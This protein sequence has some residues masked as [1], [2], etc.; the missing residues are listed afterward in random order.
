VFVLRDLE[1]MEVDE[2]TEILQITKDVVKSNLYYARIKIKEGLQ[3]YYG[4]KLVR[5]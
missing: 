2:V 3:A 5:Y 1:E 4:N